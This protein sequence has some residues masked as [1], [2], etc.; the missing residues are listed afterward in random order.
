VTVVAAAG[1]YGTAGAPSGVKYAPGNDPF[2]ITVGAADIGG[3]VWWNDDVAAPWSAWGYTYD[4]FR[5]PELAAAGRYMV[6]PVPT[7]STLAIQRADHIV[8][9]GYIQLSG[10]SFAAPV[11]SGSAAQIIARHPDWTPDQ[12]KGALMST[13]R[14][15]PSA[16]PGSVG[17][18]QITPILAASLTNPPN[19]NRSLNQ[20]VV[21]ASGGSGKVWDAASWETAVQANASWDSA[22]WLDASWLDASWLDA[23]WDTASWVDASWVDASWLDASWLDASWEDSAEGDSSFSTAFTLDQAD[24]SALKGDPMLAVPPSLLPP[25]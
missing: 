22:S 3:S 19:P 7:A 21:S 20:F 13:A 25:K 24:Q 16:V 11:V 1:N 4:G 23:S 18:G 9:P 15:M 6:G 14:K 2:V 8:A 5:K 12:V 10:T 17:V